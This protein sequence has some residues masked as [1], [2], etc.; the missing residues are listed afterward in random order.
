MRSKALLLVVLCITLLPVFGCRTDKAKEAQNQSPQPAPTDN[1]ASQPAPAPEANAPSTAP[2]TT[3]ESKPKAFYKS[4]PPVESAKK[5]SE[6]QVAPTP[7]PTPPPPIVIPAGTVLSVRTTGPISTNTAQANQEFQASLAKPL[8]VGETVVVPVG[9]PVSGVIPQAKSAG[10]IQGEGNLTLTLTS[11]TVKGKPFQ[12]A[13]KP[14]SQEAKGRGKRS[15]AMIGGGGGAGALIGGLAGGGKGAAIGGL[16]G[17]AAGTAGATMT[18]KRDVAIP[19]ETIL[20]FTLSQPL[21]LPPMQ[22]GAASQEGAP[23]LKERPHG[24]QPADAQPP[25]GSPPPA[26]QSSPPPQQPPR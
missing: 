18:G 20:S 22:G 26:T 25:Q 24:T 21:T 16:A 17:A 4:V 11:L 6:P 12:I 9:A 3:S 19:A 14:L 5:S 2:T 13:T 7:E 23:P 8:V 15:A 10:R 1:A